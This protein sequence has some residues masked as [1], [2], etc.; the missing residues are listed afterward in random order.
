MEQLVSVGLLKI[1]LCKKNYFVRVSDLRVGLVDRGIQEVDG[2]RRY[3]QSDGDA[4]NDVI[5][6]GLILT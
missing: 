2:G 5:E 1:N 4:R 3:V 6:E